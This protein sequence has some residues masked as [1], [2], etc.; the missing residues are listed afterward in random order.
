METVADKTK[1]SKLPS[2]K[3]MKNKLI[4]QIWFDGL[5]EIREKYN[6]IIFLLKLKLGLKGKNFIVGQ[7]YILGYIFKFP[8]MLNM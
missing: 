6:W 1:I 3:T 8:S 4:N 5:F 7:T 2:L